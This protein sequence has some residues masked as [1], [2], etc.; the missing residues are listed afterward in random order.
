MAPE[1]TLSPEEMS[2]PEQTVAAAEAEAEFPRPWIFG[3]KGKPVKKEGLVAD[4]LVAAGAFDSW[5]RGPSEYG[6]GT[7]ILVLVIAGERRSVWLN[8][9]VLVTKVARKIAERPSRDFDAGERI[10]VTRLGNE[11][12]KSKGGGPDYWDF[13]V[14]CPDEPPMSAA[15]A[16]GATL[17][18]V[19]TG[20]L[21]TEDDVG[22]NEEPKPDEGIPF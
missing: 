8:T 18:D 9:T 5:S 14:V 22:K 4:G 2:S 10:V 17:K 1:E 7:P 21:A 12:R 19:E 16:L 15:G 3:E 11:K 6:A 13:S 20:R